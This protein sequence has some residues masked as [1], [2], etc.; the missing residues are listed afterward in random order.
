MSPALPRS[1]TPSRPTHLAVPSTGYATSTPPFP[2]PPP[3][4]PLTVHQVR[5][6]G[7]S[8]AVEGVLAGR[9]EVELQQL[10]LAPADGALIAATGEV[11]LT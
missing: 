10:Q 4:P 11:H 3:A 5:L 1:P 6:H 7:G 2:F 8:D 9:V